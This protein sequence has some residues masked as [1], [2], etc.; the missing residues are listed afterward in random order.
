M[1]GVSKPGRTTASIARELGI[2]PSAASKAIA[3]APEALE[4]E[5]IE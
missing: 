1:G 3:L 5:G 4:G 2:S